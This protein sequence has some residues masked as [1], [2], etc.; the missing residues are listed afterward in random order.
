MSS[1]WLNESNLSPF[2]ICCAGAWQGQAGERRRRRGGTGDTGEQ[3]QPRGRPICSPNHPVSSSHSKLGK[4]DLFWV[5]G[6]HKILS[7]EQGR[8][9]KHPRDHLGLEAARPPW[10][11]LPGHAEVPPIPHPATSCTWKTPN[12]ATPRLLSLYSGCVGREQGWGG[13]VW[14]CAPSLLCPSLPSPELHK[15]PAAEPEGSE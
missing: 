3:G 1:R 4:V 11:P 8:A 13:V 5:R 9:A 7:R 6:S 12:P 2:F 10:S 14:S 15:I